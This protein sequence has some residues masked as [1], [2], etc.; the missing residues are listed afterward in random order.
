M[1]TKQTGKWYISDCA[2]RMA[3]ICERG[4]K[5]E[6]D[7][8]LNVERKNSTRLIFNFVDFTHVRTVAIYEQS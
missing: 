8:P 1:A 6:L 7:K 4:G 3:Y 5:Y 2:V